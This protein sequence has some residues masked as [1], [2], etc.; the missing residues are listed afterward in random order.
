M[1][2]VA[3]SELDN[4]S[5]SAAHSRRKLAHRLRPGDAGGRIVA[6]GSPQDLAK[7]PGQSHTSRVLAEFLAERTATGVQ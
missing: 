7:A 2:A 3:Q 5:P 1:A 6:Q 4:E